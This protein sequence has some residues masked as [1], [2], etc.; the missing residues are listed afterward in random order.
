MATGPVLAAGPQTSVAGVWSRTSSHA[1][2]L[3]AQL[4]VPAFADVETLLD[5]CD[6]VAICVAPDAQPAYAVR[7][8]QSGK[9]LLVE[10]PLATDVPGAE[11]IVEAVGA[12][13][14]GALVMLSHRYNP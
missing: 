4:S 2:E 5:A 9:A 13:G 11:A 1:D 14:V 12:A 6:A 3:A 10:K 7:A 8:A